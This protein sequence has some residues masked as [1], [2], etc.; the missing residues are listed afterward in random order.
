VLRN[1]A[2]L[3]R[4]R[5]LAFVLV[6]REL[7]ARYRGSFLGFFWSLLNPLLMLA[8]YSV[9]FG[10]LFP[11][12]GA[13]TSPYALFLFTGLLPWTWLSGSLTDASAS[14]TTHGALLK[15][16][17]FP[18][19]VLPLVAVAAQGAHFLLA[20]PVL[21]AGLA[22]GAAGVLGRPVPLGWT[23]LQA[24]PLCLIE[25]VFAAG[26]GLFLAALTVHFRDVKDLLAT[27]LTLWFF[28]TPVLYALDDIQPASLRAALLWNPATP[29]FEAWHDALFRAAWIAPERWA[30]L[31]ALS[32]TAFLLGYALF[33]RLRDSF[34]EAV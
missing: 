19:E 28:A 10:F 2:G 15:K 9:V 34:A 14:L 1:L 24:V 6:S 12:R 25:G 30:L 23:L 29:L 20:L 21:G 27:S 32:L 7:K 17:L 22:L 5:A 3:W 31:L 13:A 16:I 8:V 26:L 33:D 4:H 11:A 18:A